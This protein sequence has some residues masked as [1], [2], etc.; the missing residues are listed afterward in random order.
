MESNPYHPMPKEK[1]KQKPVHEVRIGAIKAA[2][3]KNDTE[4]GARY[5]TTFTRLYRENDE[6]Q[7]TD[8]FGRD[9]LLH[10]HQVIAHVL[11]LMVGHHRQERHRRAGTRGRAGMGRGEGCRR[12]LP[13]VT[14]VAAACCILRAFPR[15]LRDRCRL[16]DCLRPPRPAAR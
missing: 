6:W 1:E 16:D 3:W 9:D 4:K 13:G 2:V 15:R 11:L 14:W 10:R 8:S 5:N 12:T 7:Y